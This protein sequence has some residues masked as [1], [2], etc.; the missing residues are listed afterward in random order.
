MLIINIFP[1]T[2]AVIPFSLLL[3]TRNAL[4]CGHRYIVTNG[5]GLLVFWAVGWSLLWSNPSLSLF[6]PSHYLATRVVTILPTPYSNKAGSSP[7]SFSVSFLVNIFPHGVF[8]D[9]IDF[10]RCSSNIIGERRNDSSKLTFF[11][12]ASSNSHPSGFPS[13]SHPTCVE[14]L[15]PHPPTS[16]TLDRNGRISL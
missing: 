14:C 3:L 11:A 5:R 15:V 4:L 2:I 1:P 9:R 7:S 16:W 12:S 8:P 13:Y 10:C 6:R